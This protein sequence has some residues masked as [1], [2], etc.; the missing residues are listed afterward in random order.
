MYKC[1]EDVATV[2]SQQATKAV[3]Q[4]PRPNTLPDFEIRSLLSIKPQPSMKNQPSLTKHTHPAERDKTREKLGESETQIQKRG[5]KLGK[6]KRGEGGYKIDVE[7]EQPRGF[8]C[9]RSDVT[10]RWKKTRAFFPPFVIQRKHIVR[11]VAHRRLYL[12]PVRTDETVPSA[13]PLR[14]RT[15]TGNIHHFFL[16]NRK[17]AAL[18]SPL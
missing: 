8:R 6:K 10:L 11:P 7:R 17:A 9:A 16:F 14:A 12:Q 1:N 3:S 2:S 18:F 13:R 5:K 15:N 4:D